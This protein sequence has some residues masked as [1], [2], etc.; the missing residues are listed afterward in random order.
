MSSC[1]KYNTTTKKRMLR[2]EY[3]ISTLP[4]Y[5]FSFLSAGIECKTALD[6]LFRLSRV[7]TRLI[8]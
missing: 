6:H 7:R 4:N 1:L 3:K 2:G 5:R 8:G